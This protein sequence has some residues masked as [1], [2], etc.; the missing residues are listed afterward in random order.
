MRVAILTYP[1]CRSPRL[2]A[3]GLQRMLR[4]IGVEADCHA[5]A[6]PELTAMS[7]GSGSLRAILAAW[8][9][10]WSHWRRQLDRYDLLVVSDTIGVVRRTEALALL[11]RLGRPILHYE[12]FAYAGSQ[13]F[14][15]QFGEKAHHFFDGFL[16]V[17]GIHDDTPVPGPPIFEIGMDL[18][19]LAPLRPVRP[20]T[21]LMDFE[22]PGYEPQRQTQL[23]A[24]RRTGIAHE[25]LAGEYTF[26]EIDAVYAR[27][28][29]AFV[30]FP[31][32]F[33]VPVVQLQRHGCLV[34]APHPHWVKRH[35]LRPAGHVFDEAGD[36]DAFSENFL[37]YD[38]GD[39]LAARLTQARDQ[40]DASAAAARLLHQQPHFVRGRTE[41]L[42][43][44]LT[45]FRP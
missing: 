20:F 35:A 43:A 29:V 2:L 33:G 16:V 26:A 27:A 31:E 17:S 25:T 44:A 37:F 34:A 30:A 38:G 45:H 11:K 28:G 22:R 19:A 13:Y 10:R 41:A 21:A 15:R 6:L 14:V 42:Q 24:L 39:D 7:D 32:A 3:E 8:R 36:R 18:P 40:F 12:V 1:N 5:D 4:R 23:E 9:A